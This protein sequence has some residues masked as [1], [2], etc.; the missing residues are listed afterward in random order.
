[1]NVSCEYC[2]RDQPA[3]NLRLIACGA[4]LP[5]PE[6]AT[7]LPTSEQGVTLKEGLAAA[8]AVGGLLFALLDFFVLYR[9]G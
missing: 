3:E 6:P 9:A 7:S 5:A 4:P 2:G 8:S 1:M